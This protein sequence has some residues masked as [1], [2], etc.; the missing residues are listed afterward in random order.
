MSARRKK[1]ARRQTLS[2]GRP[3][4]ARVRVQV[5]LPPTLREY[6]ALV[7]RR[8]GQLEQQIV[9]ARMDIRRRAARLLREGSHQLGRLEALGE[10]RWRGLTDPYR[11]ELARMLRR[12]ERA[13]APPER[14]AR[15][16]SAPRAQRGKRR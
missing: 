11:R 5:D 8:L 16:R 10:R 6:V 3:A 7:R 2:L 15:S 12:L 13:V 9:R 14:Q 4:G 1:I